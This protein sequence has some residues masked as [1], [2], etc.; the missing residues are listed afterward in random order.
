[1]SLYIRLDA[2][3]WSH[4][5][6]IR[7]RAILGDSALWLPP[8]LWS[9][10]SQNQPDGDFSKY[11]PEEIA[12]LLAYA[13]DAKAMLGALQ[14]AGFV[15]QDMKIHGWAEHNAYH[16][17]YAERASKAATAR[18]EKHREREEKKKQKKKGKE[19]S[20]AMLPASGALATEEEVVAYCEEI[21]LRKI[22]GQICFNRWQTNGWTIKGNPIKVWKSA[23]QTLKLQ[24]YLPHK[25][26]GKVSNGNPNSIFLTER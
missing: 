2:A 22:D 7:L 16:Q 12:L 19:R 8:R 1:M 13:G 23:I 24:G 20:Q 10:A 15:D 26:N 6:T 21:G 11:L 3:F 4:R 9:Y 18:W 25:E 17:E 5:K 14:Q